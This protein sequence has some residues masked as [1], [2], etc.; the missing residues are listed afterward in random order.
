MHEQLAVVDGLQLAN[1]EASACKQQ[2]Q[3]QKSNRCGYALH[4]HVHY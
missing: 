2:G 1:V 3:Y 4:L